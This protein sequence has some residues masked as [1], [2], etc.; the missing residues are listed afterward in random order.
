M[1]RAVSAEVFAGGKSAHVAMAARALGT[2][3]IWLGFLGGAAGE[4]CALKL[5]GLGVEVCDIQTPSPTRFNL[6]I[7]D[8]T[9]KVTEI[10]EPGGPPGPGALEQMARNLAE[11]LHGNWKNASVAISGS[12]PAG[13]PKD[14]YASL[15]RETNSQ[16]SPVFLDTSGE[17]LAASLAAQPDLVKINRDEARGLLKVPVELVADVVSA[18]R[19]IIERGAK[20][21]AITLGADGLIWV[22][23]ENG[24]AWLAKPPAIKAIS[25]VGCGDA[26]LAGFVIALSGGLERSET[27]RF[28]TACGAA[29]CIAP[30]PGAIQRTDLDAILPQVAVTRL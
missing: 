22:D 23:A 10:L 26:T 9:G 1:N 13:V 21:V 20:S 25:T 14:L 3:A 4:E 2:R 5:R 29:N 27:A 12:L 6:E 11:G 28:A 16:G 8:D 15:I 30:T 17:A 7:I 24:T 19:Q 18:A